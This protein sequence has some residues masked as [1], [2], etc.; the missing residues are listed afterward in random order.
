MLSIVR[1]FIIVISVSSFYSCA[2]TTSDYCSLYEPIYYKEGDISQKGIID[3]V[4]TNN[5][6]YDK[7][8]S[9]NP[10]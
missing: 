6:L 10:L 2:T 9:K 3:A 8:C 4:D 1:N 7:L 5:A